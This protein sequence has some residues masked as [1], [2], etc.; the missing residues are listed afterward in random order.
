MA[1]AENNL[2]NS[3][4]DERSLIPAGYATAFSRNL[5]GG[6]PTAITHPYENPASRYAEGLVLRHGESV[7]HPLPV[8][9]L[10]SVLSGL[11]SN[12][13]M[14]HRVITPVAPRYELPRPPQPLPPVQPLVLAPPPAGCGTSPT[15]VA[16]IGDV[17][18]FV[19]ARYQQNS[20]AC[21][22]GGIVAGGNVEG[23]TTSTDNAVARYDGTSGKVIQ[24]SDLVVNDPAP[25]GIVVHTPDPDG[26]LAQALVVRPGN[27]SG[28]ATGPG[29]KL[30]LKGGDAGSADP[31]FDGGDVEIY[32]GSQPAGGNP[33]Q[34]KIGATQTNGVTIG[35]SGKTNTMQGT[36]TIPGTDLVT[37]GLAIQGDINTGVAGTGSDVLSLVASGSYGLVVDGTS[38]GTPVVDIPGFLKNPVGIGL[39]LQ[40]SR[41][42][43]LSSYGNGIWA[44]AWTATNTARLL[45][46]YDGANDQLLMA[47]GFTRQRTAIT[48]STTLTAQDMGALIPVTVSGSASVTLPPAGSVPAGGGIGLFRTDASGFAVTILRN[49][50]DTINSNTNSWALFESMDLGR[51]RHVLWFISDG[52]SNWTVLPFPFIANT[53]ILKPTAGGTGFGSYAVGDLLFADTT[54]SLAKLADIATGNALISGGV[55]IAPSWGKIGLTT[56]VSGT[57]P[58]ANGG[59]GATSENVALDFLI[60]GAT[61]ETSP[62]K[63]DFVGIKDVSAGPGRK[64]TLENLL[65]VVNDLTE[66][67]SPDG[68]SDFL[69]SYDASASGARKVKPNN[70]PPTGTK[71]TYVTADEAR[72]NATPTDSIYLIYNMA[73][74][75]KYKVRGLCFFN[76]NVVATGLKFGF[77]IPSATINSMKVMAKLLDGTGYFLVNRAT[78]SST[79]WN[80]AGTTNTNFQIEIDGTI[81]IGGTGGNFAII[82]SRSIGSGTTTLQRNSYL[83]FTKIV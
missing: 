62:A 46:H 44:K 14:S 26:S 49:G 56:H 18:E 42:S 65:K 12:R 22:G 30:T 43:Q 9:D 39:T 29:A 78:G 15:N 73:A 13:P 71:I 32:G 72:T 36:T 55:N 20:A 58:I 50:T 23:P 47:G 75:T 2:A 79:F 25:E 4:V 33:G 61:E 37:P 57:L 11:G 8:K 6:S 24:N 19:M 63:G 60:G 28:A 17:G 74:N 10:R 41:P 70:L 38:P 67:T 35:A 52:S 81:E 68:A 53:G 64:M 34:V 27:P 59:T 40:S 1:D 21:V 77:N 51:T 80:T 66:D 48:G 69:L 7:V 16:F 5:A 76:L 3:V 54:L 83:E 45:N 82:F 31:G